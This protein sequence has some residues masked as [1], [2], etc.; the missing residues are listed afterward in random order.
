MT[1]AERAALPVMHPGRV[2]VIGAGALVLDAVMERVGVDELLVSEADILDGIAWSVGG[3]RDP[4][5]YRA[6]DRQGERYALRWRTTRTRSRGWRPAR[7]RS[8][9]STRGRRSAGPA[10]GWW[11]G[12]SRSR[13]EKRASFRDET[14]W[15]RPITGWG[16]EPA[17]DR[18]DGARAGRAR[19]QPHRADLHR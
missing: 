3:E 4:A 5:G 18:G 10:P 13:E 7:R 9:T 19:R 1:R 12:A 2:D 17:A 15:G 11:R 14:Y 16:V 6:P 8:T